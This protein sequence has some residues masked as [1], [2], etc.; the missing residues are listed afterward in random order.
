MHNHYETTFVMTPVLSDE[1]V[2]KTVTGYIDFLQKNNAVIVLDDHWGLKQL[3]YPIGKK[4]TGIYHHIEFNATSDLI[5]KLELMYRRDENNVIRFLTIKLDKHAVLYNDK[6][7]QGLA[8][9]NKK[10]SS[11][12]KTEA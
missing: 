2:K 12:A 4:T 10:I 9:R 6:K 7:R 1:E 3:A 5:D 8:G 11:P